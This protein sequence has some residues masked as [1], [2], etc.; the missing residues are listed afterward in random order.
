MLVTPFRY[1]N[2]LRF[3]FFDNIFQLDHNTNIDD[4]YMATINLATM[5]MNT[6]RNLRLNKNK[7]EQRKKNKIRS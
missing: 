6:H 7:E 1:L 3:Y 2:F 5:E 4:I